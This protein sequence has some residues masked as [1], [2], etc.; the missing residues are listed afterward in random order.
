MASDG[1]TGVPP[2]DAG[3]PSVSEIDGA[4]AVTAAS[5]AATASGDGEWSCGLTP[6]GAAAPKYVDIVGAG[7][8]GGASTRAATLGASARSAVSDAFVSVASPAP[9]RGAAT[10]ARCRCGA[11]L[12]R[13]ARSAPALCAAAVALPPGPTPRWP[14][15]RPTV[16]TV[17]LFSTL[18]MAGVLVRVQLGLFAAAYAPP[19]A[20]MYGEEFLLSNCLGCFVIG[21]VMAHR[22]TFGSAHA[23]LAFGIATG[24]CGSLT[25]FSAWNNEG[26]C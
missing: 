20:A 22:R 15:G 9:A 3:G 10:R 13:A 4:D 21:A 24:F 26:R 8:T 1:A 2:G 17:L 6:G 7:A 23:R 11:C 19:F 25:T 18:A 5:T 14:G 16:H 12:C